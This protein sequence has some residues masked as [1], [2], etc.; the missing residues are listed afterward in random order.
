MNPPK[1]TI[2]KTNLTRYEGFDSQFWPVVV[3]L[4]VLGGVALGSFM[5]FLRGPWLWTSLLGLPVAL[6][7]GI[8]CFSLIDN[9]K[10]RRSIQ[11]GFLI[12]VICHLLLM[13]GSFYTVIF[14]ESTQVAAPR[15]K[16]IQRKTI[17]RPVDFPTQTWTDVNP[18]ELPD[19]DEVEAEPETQANESPQRPQ[20]T[21]VEEPTPTVD[22]NL[23]RRP[24]SV[25]T[26]PRQQESLSR[27]SRQTDR[28]LPTSSSSADVASQANSSSAPTLA[29]QGQSDLPRQSASS[30]QSRTSE[31]V[32]TSTSIAATAERREAD[33][34]NTAASSAASSSPRNRTA[35]PQA[36]TTAQSNTPSQISTPLTQPV[37]PATE[38]SRQ[39]S[40]AVAGRQASPE[41]DPALAVTQLNPQ[42][43]S[44]TAAEAEALAQSNASKTDRIRQTVRPD[45][46]DAAETV[47]ASQ[48]QNPVLLAEA[49]TRASRRTTSNDSPATPRQNRQSPETEAT[50]NSTSSARRAT[51]SPES[52][53]SVAA[54]GT[55]QRR[56]SAQEISVDTAAANPQ[57]ITAQQPSLKNQASPQNADISRR[58]TDTQSERQTTPSPETRLSQTAVATR[59]SR[60]ESPAVEA[61]I[62]PARQT[63]E[64]SRRSIPISPQTQSPTSIEAP[65]IAQSG[66]GQSSKPAEPQPLAMTQSKAGTSGGRQSRNL[67]N[68]TAAG[69]RPALEASV[70]ARRERTTTRE[71]ETQSLAP[72]QLAQAG[73]NR[74]QSSAPNATLKAET[75]Q[76]SLL[77]GSEQPSLEAT[78]ASASLSE[79][80]SSVTQTDVSALKGTGEIDLGPPKI[81]AENMAGRGSGG[82][83][84]TL[85]NAASPL[86]EGDRSRSSQRASLASTTAAD[87]PSSP[88][89]DGGGMPDLLAE[90]PEAQSLKVADASGAAD[91]ARSPTSGDLSDSWSSERMATET[92]TAQLSRATR[93]KGG[94]DFQTAELNPA[95]TNPSG[96][97]S[98]QTAELLSQTVADIGNTTSDPGEEE[99]EDEEEKRALEGLAVEMQTQEGSTLAARSSNSSSDV[100]TSGRAGAAERQGVERRGRSESSA[101]ALG[102]LAAGGG[103]RRARATL[104]AASVAVVEDANSQGDNP[105]AV[106][107]EASGPNEAGPSA[108]LAGG[109]RGSGS[110]R[111][112][113]ESQDLAA[114]GEA[115]AGRGGAGRRDAPSKS[116]E[117]A[118]GLG[119]LA[120]SRRSRVRT[121]ASTESGAE[122]GEL[123]DKGGVEGVAIESGSGDSS[124]V[125]DTSVA[126]RA[127]SGGVRVQLNAE[128]GPGGLE[129]DYSSAAGINDRRAK[130]ETGPLQAF[131]E[132]RFERQRAG[133]L[134]TLNTAA[135]V[136]SDAFKDRE[137]QRTQRRGA[138]QTETTIENGLDFLARF[139]ETNGRWR[140]ERFG[141]GQGDATDET[142]LT[143]SDTAATGLAIL[144]FQGAGYN[145]FEYKHADTLKRALDWLV[146]N[147]DEDGGLYVETQSSSTRYARLYSHAIAALALCEAYGVTQDPEL[148]EPAQKAIDYIILTQDKTRGGWRYTPQRGADTSVSGWMMMALK[149]GQLANLEVEL[150]TYQRISK[151]LR[152]AADPDRGGHF[153][154][155]PQAPNTAEQGHGRVVSRS[156]TA[157]GLLMSLY[158]GDHRKDANFKSGV[159]YLLE[160]LPSDENAIVRDTYY[161]YYAT[162]VLR[163][164]DGVAWQQWKSRLVPLLRGS[165]VSQGEFAG[166][167]DPLGPVPDRWSAHG[168]RLY[169]TA[170]NLLSLEVDYRLLPLYIDTVR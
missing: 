6:A 114:S 52:S 5:T 159:D 41:I 161:W 135:A 83:Q 25:Q 34:P 63:T 110:S 108:A 162:Q 137:R 74:A 105:G 154:Y 62:N 156:M 146:A 139:Q 1:R 44:A 170:M 130:P 94:R 27:M 95:A 96:R 53:A 12:S 132:T 17:R 93:K 70:T 131:V 49:T 81:V 79:S 69:E 149:S 157:V 143:Q 80:S 59:A 88:L 14:G 65:A 158:L 32:E 11:L 104:S 36:N 60:S 77:A 111:S 43:A 16:T 121:L 68:D 7:L 115:M 91:S 57:R 55:T 13:T 119:Q 3:A 76:P 98:G 48:T 92:D 56:R 129:K 164:M 51:A 26:T 124:G 9:R 142:P 89:N 20:P 35:A 47:E 46:T 151:W 168:G 45:L 128:T 163:H 58:V 73:R 122:L 153:R 145:H 106:G 86:A 78:S 133:G 71:S 50:A 72:S 103:T 99:D 64:S 15:P 84:P 29:V 61:S 66:Q 141:N 109:R 10:I 42:R 148:L 37:T 117:N 123:S 150:E 169:L 8:Y 118:S 87:L 75:E 134:P 82:G 54:G 127:A 19:P 38:L 24:E 160:Q 125:G 90:T 167:W 97:K 155:N 67:E 40:K 100:E 33:N 138:P 39:P 101:A 102:G 23:V 31:Q 2:R 165:Q 28:D 18:V 144:A 166:S 30:T 21:P 4:C 147:Q 126:Q 140:L 136:A 120:T 152:D 112:P 116:S 85:A 113:A 22:P 107:L